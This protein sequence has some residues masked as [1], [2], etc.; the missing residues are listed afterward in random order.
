MQPNLFTVS[1]PS[2]STPSNLKTDSSRLFRKNKTLVMFSGAWMQVPL[3][4]ESTEQ[5]DGLF[6]FGLQVLTNSLS[7]F[8]RARRRL[9]RSHQ[10]KSRP[11]TR[12]TGQVSSA[13]VLSDKIRV[14][15]TR[16][17]MGQMMPLTLAYILDGTTGLDA[18]LSQDMSTSVDTSDVP[19]GIYIK[20]E[21]VQLAYVYRYR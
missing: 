7:L 9:E 20:E 6:P 18:R 19:P 8:P 10:L 15:R 16:A 3:K 11:A 12:E 4:S 13:C 17:G 14:P 5:I 1:S 21:Y 2:T